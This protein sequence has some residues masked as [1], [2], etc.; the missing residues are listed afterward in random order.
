MTCRRINSFYQPTIVYSLKLCVQVNHLGF[1]EYEEEAARAYDAA[2]RA[3]RGPQASTNFSEAGGS[4]NMS[5]RTI[6]TSGRPGDT[7]TVVEAIPRINVNPKCGP[8]SSMQLAACSSQLTTFTCLHCC[9][10]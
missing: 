6:T 1:F 8:S 5:A 9:L 7:S 2:A 3:I 4:G 10:H